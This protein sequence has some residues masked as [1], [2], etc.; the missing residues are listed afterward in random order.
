MNST[1]L[2]ADV[3]TIAP[4]AAVRPIS[5]RVLLIDK[6]IVIRTGLR[7]LIETWPGLTV[8]GETAPCPDAVTLA[9]RQQPDIILL[10]AGMGTE[11]QDL[12]L[13]PRI[14]ERAPDSRSIVLIERHDL[15][16]NQTALKLG[17]KGVLNKDRA[18]DELR[19]CISKVHAGEMWLDRSSTATF[20]AQLSRPGGRL[21]PDSAT[22]KIR[23]LTFREREVAE[24]VC[25]GLKNEDIATRLG[26]SETTVRHHISSIL[27][28]IDVSSRLE[29]II[30][31]FRNRFIR[32]AAM[33]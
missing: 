19:K 26:I 24:L 13:L 3:K 20:I 16:L 30:F 5:I 29:L 15:Q 11:I 9:E 6:H 22:A 32:K 21:G 17:A 25:E 12:E 23:L 31:L 8:V 18:A 2:D 7:M 28:K 4:L 14:Q 10:D 33:A 27:C 1:R